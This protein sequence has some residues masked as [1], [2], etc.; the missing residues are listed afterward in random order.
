MA[1]TVRTQRAA[2]AAGAADALTDD[3]IVASV[4]VALVASV[5]TTSSIATWVLA[6]LAREPVCAQT[7]QRD[8]RE[9]VE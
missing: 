7:L 9:T 8:S 5:D 3:E 6:H 1:S 2:A 4:S